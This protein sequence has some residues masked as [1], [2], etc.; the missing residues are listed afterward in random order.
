MQSWK[1]PKGRDN[2]IFFLRPML[3]RFHKG[4]KREFLRILISLTNQKCLGMFF[5]SR[6]RDCLPDVTKRRSI[7]QATPCI[8]VML[9]KEMWFM[10]A[11][12]TASDRP[13]NCQAAGANQLQDHPEK[14]RVM[15]SGL[16][17]H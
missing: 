6:Y 14:D 10:L 12:T 8:E 16:S 2:S 1:F 4:N 11:H 3:Q 13:P 17:F 5:A 7:F 9:Y 15:Q